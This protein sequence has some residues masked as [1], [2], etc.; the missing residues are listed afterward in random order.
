MAKKRRKNLS[1]MLFIMAA[2][3][4][5]GYVV[6]TLYEQQQEMNQLRVVEAENQ[7]KIELMEEELNEMQA[8]IDAAN[9]DEHVEKI[10]REQLKMIGQDEVL[11]IDLGKG[12]K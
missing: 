4:L 12:A 1:G 10:A 2:L 9:S 11:F 6:Y 8:D 5:C 7:K 3:F